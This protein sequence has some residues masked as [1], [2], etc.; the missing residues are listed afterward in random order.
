[1]LRKQLGHTSAMLKIILIIDLV[2]L[3]VLLLVVTV[4][5]CYSYHFLARTIYESPANL[6]TILSAN[7]YISLAFSA[8]TVISILGSGA[9]S[10]VAA[11]SLKKK[12]I[13]NTVS[14]WVY[15]S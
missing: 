2:I 7:Q 13:A 10:L 6:S 3:G 11:R 9:L 14:S 1:M 12:H 4:L 15:T 5:I 8:V